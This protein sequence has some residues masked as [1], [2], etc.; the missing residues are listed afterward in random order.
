MQTRLH[1]RFPS[2]SFISQAEFSEY[3]RVA[4]ASLDTRYLHETSL[5]TRDDAVVQLGTCAPC[6]RRAAFTS[7]TERW[8]RLADGRR[9]PEWSDGLAC[10]CA[11]H[12]SNRWRALLHFAQSA[13][14]LRD[15]TRLLLL[16]PATP[17]DV[18]LTALAGAATW[19]PHL[20]AGESVASDLRLPAE[21]GAFH[22]A[23]AANY[24]HRVPPLPAAFA[25]LRRVLAP[26]GSLVFTVPFR[27]RAAR[28]VSRA[29]PQ[30]GRPAA[31]HREAVHEIGWDV[32]DMLRAAGFGRAS[33]HSYWSNELGYLGP[34]NMILHAVA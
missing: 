7:D 16:G 24:L 14:G 3:C 29:L 33:V 34:F 21:S 20:L 27:Y 25:E 18:R 30:T 6:L 17:A 15:W 1:A 26:G 22:L 4:Q 12:L 8:E 11:D 10:D 19:L 28:T 5:T 2:V 9:V 32:L 13:G 23:I 31:E